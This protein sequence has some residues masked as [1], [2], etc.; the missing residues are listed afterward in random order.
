MNKETN[1]PELWPIEDEEDVDARRASVGLMPLA[2]YL[3]RFGLD[4]SS[5]AKKMTRV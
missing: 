4:Y 5:P 2:E 1:R 3:K